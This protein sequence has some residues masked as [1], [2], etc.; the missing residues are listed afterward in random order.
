MAD[1]TVAV[2]LDRIIVDN[3][4]LSFILFLRVFVRIF[5]HYSGSHSVS[6]DNN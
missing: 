5:A 1:S 2:T 4:N 6:C 3:I